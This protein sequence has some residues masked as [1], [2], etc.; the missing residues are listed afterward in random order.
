MYDTAELSAQSR[1]R[2]LHVV[3]DESDAASIRDDLESSPIGRKLMELLQLAEDIDGRA[4]KREG[5][6]VQ[7]FRRHSFRN[8]PEELLA[9]WLLEH[10]GDTSDCWAVNSVVERM[11]S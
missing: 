10:V 7:N 8:T 3:R 5:E 11:A 6:A 9:G 4:A 2:A 1:D